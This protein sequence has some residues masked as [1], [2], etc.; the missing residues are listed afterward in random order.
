MSRF[1]N[2]FSDK[3]KSFENDGLINLSTWLDHQRSLQ[4]IVNIGHSSD[5]QILVR[6]LQYNSTKKDK[7]RLTETPG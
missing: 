1:N 7:P 3:L 6:L 5:T 2:F 4:P